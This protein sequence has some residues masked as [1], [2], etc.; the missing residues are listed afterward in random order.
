M[1]SLLPGRSQPAST[2]VPPPVPSRFAGLVDKPDKPVTP[3]V[4]T[5]SSSTDAV[6]TLERRANPSGE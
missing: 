2:N 1:E 3:G 4:A 5:P 6:R